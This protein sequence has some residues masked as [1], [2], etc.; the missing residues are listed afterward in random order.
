MNH[1]SIVVFISLLVSGSAF[2]QTSFQTVGIPAL[3]K[4]VVESFVKTEQGKNCPAEGLLSF[5]RI[6]EVTGS[7][8]SSVDSVARLIEAVKGRKDQLNSDGSHCGKCQ[9][10]NQVASYTTSEPSRTT[11]NSMCN[12][13]PTVN[14]RKLLPMDQIETFVDS[15]L[16]GRTPEGRSLNQGCPD[17]CSFYIASS[18]TERDGNQSMINLTVHCGQPRKGSILFADYKYTAGLIQSWSCK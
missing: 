8:V 11:L 12:N 17:P 16:R 14:I 3:K 7:A 1:A 5:D 18:T 13:R 2:A 4:S 10:I 9:E 6:V 15:T